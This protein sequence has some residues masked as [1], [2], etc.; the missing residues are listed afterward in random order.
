VKLASLAVCLI[1]LCSCSTLPKDDPTPQSAVSRQADISRYS[2]WRAEGRISLSSPQQSVAGALEWLQNGADYRVGLTAFLGQR[3]LSIE[4]HADWATLQVRG[5][6]KITGA[7]AESLLRRRLGVRVPLSQLAFW[8]RGLPGTVGAAQYDRF[9]RLYSIKYQD[10]DGRD[11][12]AR[13]KQYSTVQELD[14]PRTIE[15]TDGEHKIRLVLSDW[16]MGDIQKKPLKRPTDKVPSRIL[17]PGAS[18]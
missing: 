2:D 9:G 13:V 18:A 6:N 3:A 10:P 8:I 15:V 5:D 11:W 7:S 1:L 4:Q 16:V 17:I 12:R 14:L